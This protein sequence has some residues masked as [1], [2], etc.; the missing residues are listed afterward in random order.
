M[1]VRALRLLWKVMGSWFTYQ[2]W[3]KGLRCWGHGSVNTWIPDGDAGPGYF[4]IGIQHNTCLRLA[5]HRGLC[6][7]NWEETTGD[8]AVA[9]WSYPKE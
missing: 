8:Y 1:R 3:W 9:G 4:R 5:K 7:G 6:L 2:D